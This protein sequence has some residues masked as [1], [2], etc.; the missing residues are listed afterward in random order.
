MEKYKRD[1]I[2]PRYALHLMYTDRRA[3]AEEIFFKLKPNPSPSYQALLKMLNPSK[4]EGIL[5]NHEKIAL[6]EYSNRQSKWI[7]AIHW[8][9]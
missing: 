6:S 9:P 4:F 8:L 7:E 1:D 5:S 2:L 3:K